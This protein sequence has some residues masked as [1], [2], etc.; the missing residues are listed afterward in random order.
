[1]ADERTLWSTTMV[2]RRLGYS[3][4]TIRSMCEAGSF[5][6][7]FRRGPGGHHW[8]IPREDVETFLA[9]C[10]PRVRRRRR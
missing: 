6:G 7:A 3:D 10:R 5:P 2:A 8:R 1:M 9:S 4:E